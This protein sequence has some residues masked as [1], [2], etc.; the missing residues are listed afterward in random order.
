MV[1]SGNFGHWVYSDIHLFPKSKNPD[2]RALNELSHQIFTVCF[3]KC[4]FILTVLNMKELN[5]VTVRIS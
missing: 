4:F 3:V 5:I 1:I 2:E